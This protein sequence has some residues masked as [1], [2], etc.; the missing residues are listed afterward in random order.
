MEPFNAKY[1]ISRLEPLTC[2]VCIDLVFEKITERDVSLHVSAVKGNWIEVNTDR[3]HFADI[4][5]VLK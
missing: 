1:E 5:F 3:V 2:V 4:L